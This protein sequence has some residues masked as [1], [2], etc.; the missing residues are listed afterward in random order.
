MVWI[1]IDSLVFVG[2]VWVDPIHFLSNASTFS[3]NIL[4]NDYEYLYYLYDAL[5]THWG[6]LSFSFSFN[7]S[8]NPFDS[9]GSWYG[10]KYSTDRSIH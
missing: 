8:F 2:M 5:K 7:I 9:L 1:E 3:I 6:S 4:N 10:L